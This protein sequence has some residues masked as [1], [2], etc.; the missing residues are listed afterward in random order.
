MDAIQTLLSVIQTQ[1]AAAAR[2][3]EEDKARVAAAEA[4]V[5]AL[6]ESLAAAA[7]A[8]PPPAVSY[9]AAAAA[10]APA[11]TTLRASA[12]A[13]RG[14]A[15]G[16]DTIGFVILKIGTRATSPSFIL[17]RM[18]YATMPE[19]F[20][21]SEAHYSSSD[22]IAHYTLQVGGGDRSPLRFHVYFAPQPAP[23]QPR[24]LLV[25]ELAPHYSGERAEPRL[26]ALFTSERELRDAWDEPLP[27]WLERELESMRPASRAGSVRSDEYE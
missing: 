8:R 7:A 14:R 5:R 4:K 20:S 23:H 6:E 22:A 16:D 9:A 3:R 10:P 2:E 24:Y 19:R 18:M 21:L 26:A 15:R 1:V 11:A 13:W 27:I 25:S 12:P 17:L